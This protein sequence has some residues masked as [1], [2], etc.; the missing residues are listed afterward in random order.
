MRR[1]PAAETS[2]DAPIDVVWSVMTDTDRY[3]E[4]NP[5]V[6]EVECEQPPVTG[7]PIRLHVEFAGGKQVTSPERITVLE[8]P[9]DDDGVQRA[10]MAYVYEGWPARLGLVRGTRWQRLTQ[11]A[12]GPTRY[13]T[14]EEFSGPLVPLAGPARVEEGFRRHAD[15]LRRRAEEL[16]RRSG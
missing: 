8:P 13:A 14:V 16:S 5:F 3:P 9:Y 1:H 12:G 7:T 2:I 6:R 11:E 15:A 10:T 4:W